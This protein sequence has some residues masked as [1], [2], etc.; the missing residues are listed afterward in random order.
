[1][2]TCIH[3]YT[4]T[5]MRAYLDAYIHTYMHTHIHTAVAT[6][7]PLLQTT[8]P[9]GAGRRTCSS[10]SSS[11]AMSSESPPRASPPPSTPAPR[12]DSVREERPARGR[13]C[14]PEQLPRG[15]AARQGKAPQLV[16]GAG[17]PLAPRVIA[18]STLGSSSSSGR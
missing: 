18:L 1:M 11:A 13:R 16:P 5:Y 2:H 17:G 12:S 15:P 8:A 6:H 10:R 9:Y 4:H 7:C 14:K 3:T